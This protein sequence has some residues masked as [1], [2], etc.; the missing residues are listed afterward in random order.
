MNSE[1]VRAALA[2][3]PDHEE[4]ILP[5]L[6]HLFQHAGTGAIEEYGTIEETFAPEALSAM[7]DWITARFPKRPAASAGR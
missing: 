5:G 3:N 7:G 2:G 4:R 1:G 6:N